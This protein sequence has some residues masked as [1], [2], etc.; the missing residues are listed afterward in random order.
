[1]VLASEPIRLIS[2][3]LSPLSLPLPLV[4][5]AQGWCNAVVVSILLNIPL[6]SVYFEPS[7]LPFLETILGGRHVNFCPL[8]DVYSAD[9]PCP[10]FIVISGTID[11]FSKLQR[12]IRDRST[13]IWIMQQ[14]FFGVKPRYFQ[15]RVNQAAS[16][17]RSVGL[18]PVKFFHRMY[19]GATNALHLISF[20]TAFGF[21]DR[22]FVHP[23]NVQTSSV[24]C[25]T[26]G[27]QLSPCLLKSVAG[28][29]SLMVISNGP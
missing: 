6:D 4:L 17:S 5:V 21:Q 26:F 18:H 8:E 22:E 29:P 28:S 24:P 9:I 27:S 19:G 14:S 13:V 25:V 23:P 16:F 7:L 15:N 10:A 11:F 3:T 1:M 12:V 2:G 20:G